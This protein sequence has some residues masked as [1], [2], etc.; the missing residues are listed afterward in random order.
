MFKMKNSGD[1]VKIYDDKYAY[2]D[3]DE[4]SDD[5]SYLVTKVEDKSKSSALDVPDS[6]HVEIE[7]D[8]E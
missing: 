2:L 4:E 3:N 6:K 8:D 1:T 5:R 7:K